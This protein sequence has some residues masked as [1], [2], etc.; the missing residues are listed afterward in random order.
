MSR[1]EKGEVVSRKACAF[2]CLAVLLT[3]AA[4]ARGDHGDAGSPEPSPPA[5]TGR[6]VDAEG[7]PLSGV[8]IWKDQTFRER[9]HGIEN[10]PAAITGPDG[11]FI[12]RDV[13]LYDGAVWAT[14][15]GW[16]RDLFR[17]DGG[18]P[19]AP[20]EL[21]LRPA[22]RIAGRVVDEQGAP[23]EGALISAEM[24]GRTT[25]CVVFDSY[26][27]EAEVRTDPEGRF[28]L[29]PLEPGWFEIDVRAAGFQEARDVR[30]RSEAGRSV[31]DVEIA[32]VRNA[33]LE[34]RVVDAD[35]APV[36]GAWIGS[37]VSTDAGGMYRAYGYAPGRHRIT[38]RHE[39]QGWSTAEIDT[40]PGRNRLD[41]RLPRAVPVLGR[42]VLPDGTPALKARASFLSVDPGYIPV[43]D[44]ELRTS[45]PPGRH[46]ILVRME[47][48]PDARAR[49]E[50]Q[51][52]PVDLEIRLREGSTI[53]GRVTGLRPGET[54]AIEARG[55]EDDD[56]RRVEAGGDG[57]YR[58]DHLSP[59]TWK[60]RLD[61]R[62]RS[63]ERR[64]EVGEETQVRVD[65]RLQPTR[66]VRGR[67]LDPAG[68]PAAG[69][70]VHLVRGASALVE[71]S[72]ADGSFEVYLEDGAWSAWAQRPERGAGA[73]PL[74]PFTVQGAPAQELEIRFSPPI[75]V[76][77]RILGLA[78]GEIVHW[79][80]AEGEHP[81]RKRLGKA[82]HDGG[83]LIPDL[84]PGTWTIRA[85][86][87]ERQA[88]AVVRIAPGDRAAT[89]DLVF[90][91]GE[92]D[93]AGK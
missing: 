31:D 41:V 13:N 5:L 29:D 7:R 68:Y 9:L 52:D 53:S 6:V 83:F 46:E 62:Y 47:G 79:I 38:V 81:D 25:G 16:L 11:R 3:L 43:E 60:V 54:A 24:S 65:F 12:L 59:G 55:G 64:V 30:R 18:L 58:L 27:N 66:H 48:W 82:D 84:T 40:V 73:S 17:Y 57:S 39:E 88:L 74:V 34:G 92:S 21:R 22:G 76:S 86:R 90:P 28:I 75:P 67:V 8:E 85:A 37:Q 26:G 70:E 44:G 2:V 32:L 69:A 72:A 15:T 20:V 78:T 87:G 45:V 71:S 1:D 4:V 80:L 51:D 89:M 63:R 23:V 61:T 19:S 10:R 50:A 33:I 14:R 36:A 91:P 42:V 35:G 77:G 56:A 93:F 49:F